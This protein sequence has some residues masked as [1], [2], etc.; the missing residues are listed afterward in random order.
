[1]K[2]LSCSFNLD[3]ACVEILFDDGSS[4]MIDCTV[5]ENQY[6]TTLRRRSELDWLI[7]NE[8]L[9][10]AQMLLDGSLESYLTNVTRYP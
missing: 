6:G 7:Y 5:I 9:S 8:P 3:T 4:L 2:L 1:M 10:Y